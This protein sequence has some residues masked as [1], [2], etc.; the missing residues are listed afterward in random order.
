MAGSTDYLK[1]KYT[2]KDLDADYYE[3]IGLDYSSGRGR[4]M[5]AFQRFIIAVLVFLAVLIIGTM[6]L[7]V[8]E[9][10]WLF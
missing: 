1:V 5:S 6:F 9:R 4:G 10:I 7:V 3:S 2:L 8:T